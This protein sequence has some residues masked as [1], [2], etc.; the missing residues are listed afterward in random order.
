MGR[1]SHQGVENPSLQRD[2]ILRGRR[3]TICCVR[4]RGISI[5]F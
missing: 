2:E 4:D 5:L 3:S 1:C